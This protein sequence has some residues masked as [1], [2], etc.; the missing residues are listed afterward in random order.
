[1]TN[2]PW[3]LLNS[4]L[5][6]SP[7]NMALDEALLEAMPRLGHPV[8]RFYGWIEKA[9]SFGY[10]QK[11]ADVERMTLLRPLVRRPTAGGLVAHGADFT[12]GLIFPTNDPWYS[13]SA[14]ESYRR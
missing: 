8:L 5:S 7:F 13:L 14:T 3:L 4:G 1:M 6:D 9:A 11:F 10:F 12:Y 2:D